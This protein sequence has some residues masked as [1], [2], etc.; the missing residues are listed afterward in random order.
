MG[1]CYA[2]R[3][4][5]KLT[6]IIQELRKV[7]LCYIYLSYPDSCYPGTS[8]NRAADLPY[9]MLT[10]QKLWAIQWVWPITAY[11]FIL[12]SEI[13]TNLSYGH[14]LIP[15]RCFTVPI[16]RYNYCL[17]SIWLLAYELFIG[18]FIAASVLI[19]Q[20]SEALLH[21]YVPCWFGCN[22]AH[23]RRNQGGQRGPCPPPPPP[24]QIPKYMPSAPP[25]F[26]HQK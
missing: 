15:R 8:L 22:S 13:R 11:V 24:P 23:R 17:Y 9:F 2:H 26:P 10:L 20:L 25:R 3:I 6:D 18:C 19:V 7:C 5:A 12:Y 21:N 16:L 1:Y 4:K 14:P